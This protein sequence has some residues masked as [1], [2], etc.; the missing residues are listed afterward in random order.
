MHWLVT[1]VSVV[2]AL[3]GWRWAIR[4][5]R[6]GYRKLIELLEQIRD[7]AGGVQKLAREM[8]A[9]S[10]AVVNL[11]TQILHQQEEHTGQLKDIGELYVDLV[12]VVS[13]NRKRIERLEGAP[14]DDN[15][16]A[17]H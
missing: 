17:T 1:G 4:P 13:R 9:L 5:V 3:V 11:V 14:D 7:S 16:P 8:E 10:G 15:P 12:A 6:R 2:G